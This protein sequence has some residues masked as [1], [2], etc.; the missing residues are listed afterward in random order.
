MKKFAIDVDSLENKLQKKTAY[1]LEDVKDKIRK[2]AFD[3]VRFV[4]N[5]A[6]I[7]GLWQI[8][9][10]EDGDYIVA[11]YEDNAQ[12]KVEK[13][14]WST[15]TDKTA[16]NINIFYKDTP[17]CKVATASLN[18]PKE[19]I[20][21]ACEYLPKRLASNSKLVSSLLADIS[22][23][24]REQILELHPELKNMPASQ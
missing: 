9:K 22:K 19:D 20:L 17:V 12:A 16:E 14:A 18:I 7:D 6:T 2:V 10:H 1:R 15:I 23:E 5:D 4:D 13:T 24:R 21:F 3:V 8:Q 11:M